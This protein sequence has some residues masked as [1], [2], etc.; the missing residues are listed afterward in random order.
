MKNFISMTGIVT[1]FALVGCSQPFSVD[2]GKIGPPTKMGEF[3]FLD[4]EWN[5]EQRDQFYTTLQGNLLIPYKWF[6]HLETAEST[7]NAAILFGSDENIEKL[8]YLKGRVTKRNVDRLPVGFTKE[9]FDTDRWGIKGEENWLGVTCAACHTN[10]INFTNPVTKE[11]YKIRVDGAPTLADF[12]GFLESLNK[13]LKATL[14]NTEK[15]NRFA[16]NINDPKL[17]EKIVKVLE[18]R[19]GW[20]GRNNPKAEFVGGKQTVEDGYARLDA[21]GS[22]FNEAEFVASGL[23]DGVDN[24][25][26]FN[27][28]NSNRR[29]TNAPVSYPFL[30][31]TRWHD[32]VQWPAT[33][34][35][36][37]IAR[38][39]TEVVG[40]FG[41]VNIKEQGI[42]SSYES[43]MRLENLRRLSDMIVN[44][45]S[46]L[47]PESIFGKID[48][49]EGSKWAKGKKLFDDH[50][51][52]CHEVV[53]RDEP[54]K[55]ISVELTPLTD[56][57]TDPV[58][59]ENFQNR[60]VDPGKLKGRGL[61][62]SLPFVSLGD[63]GEV[64]GTELV[65]H[66]I[67]RAVSDDL[68]ETA[69]AFI[70]LF[71]TKF[72]GKFEQKKKDSYKG[73]PL[74]GIWA[75]A[76]YLHN[77]SVPTLA[78][79]MMPPK[80][81]D[82]VFWVGS[83]E[84]LEN[85]VGFKYE[86]YSADEKSY[87][88]EFNTMID[89]NSRLGHAYPDQTDEKNRLTEDEI[90]ALVIYQKSL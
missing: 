43:S 65:A 38:N 22:I 51:V 52:K 89:G 58:M 56:L 13:A 62:D 81:R 12:M 70:D 80:K 27:A 19:E 47:W 48:K 68:G 4:Q 90:E 66:L 53:R 5:A 59:I 7:E 77:G 49:S 16:E 86:N 46:P 88:F 11:S 73:R 87:L 1:L 8:R 85:E 50:C 69:R 30:W 40:V 20:T 75:T 60:K 28:E 21:F 14:D 15:F 63:K 83:R 33:A 71:V 45:R 29:R 54:Q 79:L 24:D 82:P 55:T 25:K 35:R 18:I 34:P 17:R 39:F 61:I 76:P 72:G 23:V 78:Q 37:P 74:E 57:G 31:G 67:A 10:Q 3:T 36:V 9:E 6:F 41:R 2:D 64:S 84:F 42:L 32:W 26:I 44:L